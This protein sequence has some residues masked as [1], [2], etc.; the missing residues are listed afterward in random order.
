MDPNQREE[1][2]E[3]INEEYDEIRDEFYETL[4]VSFLK[5]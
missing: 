4:K 3:E 2:W 1:F 5:L